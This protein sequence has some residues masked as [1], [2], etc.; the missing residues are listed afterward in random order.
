M[1]SYSHFLI[2]TDGSELATKGVEQ[3]LALAKALKAKATIFTVTQN[4]PYPPYIG[5]DVWTPLPGDM[6]DFD[7]AQK[8]AADT[9]LAAAMAQA[10]KAGVKAEAVQAAHSFPAEAILEAAGASECDLIVM[11]SHGRRGL[12]RLMLGSVTAEVVSHSTVPVLV[13][14]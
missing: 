13:V 14:R 12:G 6:D 7:A 3:G 8:R 4:F 5:A 10:K 11:A 2:T 9:L 1:A